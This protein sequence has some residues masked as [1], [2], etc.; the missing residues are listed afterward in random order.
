[1]GL[2]VGKN[3]T[4]EEVM[5]DINAE[6][7]PPRKKKKT[8][9]KNPPSNFGTSL[10]KILQNRQTI[11][12][13]PEKCFLMSLL[14]Q[15]K[16]LTEDQKSMVYI[17]FLNTIQR[18]KHYSSAMP[19]SYNSSNAPINHPPNSYYSQQHLSSPGYYYANDTHNVP[20][21]I[22][23]STITSP[24]S[25]H[26]ESS[27]FL[28]PPSPAI[29]S[30]KNSYNFSNMSSPTPQNMSTPPI[31]HAHHYVNNYS[32]PTSPYNYSNKNTP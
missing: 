27:N 26:D 17:E 20:T 10:L 32:Q 21:A 1:M 15:I 18:V 7:Q 8:L 29:N 30:T 19:H 12:E 4:I 31:H 14:P 5:D 13:D 9:I 22:I 25:L 3:I 11:P 16:S 2:V 24:Q 28:E 23:N 6:E